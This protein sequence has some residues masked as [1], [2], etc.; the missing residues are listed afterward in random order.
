MTAE[1]NTNSYETTTYT[2][3]FK[4]LPLPEA[5][6][7]GDKAL[8]GYSKATLDCRVQ[9]VRSTLKDLNQKN[10]GSGFTRVVFKEVIHE[11]SEAARMFLLRC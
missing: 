2:A 3:K 11:V 6:L 1:R 9:R 5:F 8:P 7:E 4:P 10:A